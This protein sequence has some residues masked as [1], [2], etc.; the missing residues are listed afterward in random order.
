MSKRGLATAVLSTLAVQPAL[1][2]DVILPETVV[3]ATR[4]TPPSLESAAPE[5][6]S[7]APAADGG[8][9]LRSVPGVWG[10]RFGGAGTDPTIRGQDETQLN[11]LTDGGYT[12][13]G[14]PNRMDPPTA[15]AVPETFDRVEVIKGSQTVLYGGG[16]SG[17]TV[18]FER[19][20]PP[21]REG[22]GLRAEVG[23]GYRSNADA[24]EGY[25]DVAAGT[26][27]G[28]A[29]LIGSYSD[30][31]SYED[32]DG[33]EVR[34]AYTHRDGNLLLGYT[35]DDHT[36]LEL[37][38]EAFRAEDTLYAG[39]MD[40]PESEKDG[41]RLSF[42][43]EAPVGGLDGLTVEAY[44]N[45][46]YHLMDNYSLRD[47]PMM[48]M[49]TPSDS[50]T[51]GGRVLGEVF[52]GASSHWTVGVDYQGRERE[53]IRYQGMSADN[54]NAV[55]SLMWPDIS[56]DQLG[57]FTQVDHEL[58][59]ADRVRVGLRYDRVTTDAGRADE[60]TASGTSPDD[61]YQRHYG[62]TADEQ[63]EDNVGG[64]LRYGHDFGDAVTGFATLSRAVRT[65]DETERFLA[66][67]RTM[68]MGDW[69]GNPEI[70]PEQH[71]QAELGLVWKREATRL[72][73]SAYYNDVTDY[74]L[75]DRGAQDPNGNYATIHRNVDATLIG[76]EVSAE[77]GFGKHWTA[78][79]TGSY[80]HG[81]NDTDGEALSQ[82]PPLEGTLRIAYERPAF[83][84]GG[85]VRA[86]DRQD[87]VDLASGQDLQE[88]AGYAVV[89]LFSRV[90][91]REGIKLR[92]GVDNLLDKTY[93]THINRQD[94]T[95]G[96]AILVNEPGR[97][98]WARLEAAF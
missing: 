79:L 94:S 35:P 68:M 8:E 48:F 97:S 63:T 42:E 71:H 59:S 5:E 21:F 14:C 25:A 74:I 38:A 65:A 23:G 41:A 58:G 96:E 82:I 56:Q 15:Y 57:V 46:V 84:L 86:V 45:D 7:E 49:R 66:S 47:D 87:R 43:R 17:G 90:R 4:I 44:Y 34:S 73:A 81:E 85:E 80:V 11:V 75:V 9:L 70:D 72:E 61:L 19:D 54:V 24:K 30:A 93:A 69:V 20:T 2:Q 6:L 1:A 55:Q 28:Y 40:S 50:T 51:Y 76:G 12:H 52:A 10:S 67:E 18:R 62:T 91:L 36:T 92:L 83:R 88:T 39:M 95:S 29:R 22:E 27:T 77:Q 26:P 16:G 32:G 37:G 89:N 60:A 3:E 33:N 31:D 53:A 64:L 78:R 98:V 13:G